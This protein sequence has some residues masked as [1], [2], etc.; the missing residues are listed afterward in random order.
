M[1]RRT[2]PRLGATGALL[3][4]LAGCGDD[5]AD[6]AGGAGTDDPSGTGG[7]GAADVPSVE[8]V[9]AGA[10]PRTQLRLDVDEGYRE[11]VTMVLHQ[12]SAIEGRVEEAPTMTLRYSQSVESVTEDEIEVAMAY[13]DVRVVGRGPS[14]GV[15]RSLEESL[16]PLEGITGTTTFAPDGSVLDAEVDVP[17]DVPD[18]VRSMIQQLSSQAAVVSV[19]MPSEPVGEGAVWTVAGELALAGIDSTQEATYTLESVEGDRYKVAVEVTQQLEGNGGGVLSGT[20]EGTGSHTWE[21]GRLT[22]VHGSMTLVNTTVVEGPDDEER[23]FTSEVRVEL[24]S[25]VR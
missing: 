24:S 14:R 18:P 9:D 3:L 20:G 2:L 23:E 15:A 8:V 22:P 1:S 11:T 12:T 19:P 16:A 21:P 17:D 6:G 10:E 5:G 13:E 4:A 7:T 25:E